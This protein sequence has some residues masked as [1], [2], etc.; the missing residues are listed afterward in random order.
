MMRNSLEYDD[1]HKDDK[2]LYHAKSLPELIKTNKPIKL[3]K[4]IEVSLLAA[5][6]PDRGLRYLIRGKIRVDESKCT[7][8]GLCAKTCI[9]QCITLDPFP[10]INKKKCC[11]CLGCLNLCTNDALDAK[12]TVGKERYKGPGKLKHHPLI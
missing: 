7:K 1:P 10:I 4:K 5:I 8:C 12:N 3:K 6:I 2:M 11:A 9:S